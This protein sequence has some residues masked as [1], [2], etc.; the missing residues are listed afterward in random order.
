MKNM[1]EINGTEGENQ[2]ICITLTV[3]EVIEII[4][5]WAKGYDIHG[6]PEWLHDYMNR[7][8]GREYTFRQKIR[9]IENIITFMPDD[10]H[11]HF[12][13]RVLRAFYKNL[14]DAQ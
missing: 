9:F 5:E 8:Y 2:K 12:I 3:D 1:Q 4:R 6:V 7:P 11:N 13:R 10:V 14:G